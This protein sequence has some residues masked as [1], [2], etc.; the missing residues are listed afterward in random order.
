MTHRIATQW[1]SGLALVIAGAWLLLGLNARSAAVPAGAASTVPAIAGSSSASA[2]GCPVSGDLV[3]DGLPE[4]H[5][6][7]LLV[8][9]EVGMRAGE[10]CE[11]PF[12]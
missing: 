10:L 1:Y 3:G 5:Q 2:V 9:Q 6:R 8:I 11:A 4:D 12:D 7:M